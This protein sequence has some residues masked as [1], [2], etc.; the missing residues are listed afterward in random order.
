MVE[1]RPQL[2]GRGDILAPV[3]ERRHLFPNTSRPKAIN[4]D[5]QTVRWCGW[6][7]NALYRNHFDN[8]REALICLEFRRRERLSPFYRQVG[9]GRG[10]DSELCEGLHGH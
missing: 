9:S 7:V 2:G 8:L 3:V 10:I 6:I 4:K 1:P 5:A